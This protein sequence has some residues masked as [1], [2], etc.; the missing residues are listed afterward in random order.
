[1]CAKLIELFENPSSGEKEIITEKDIFTEQLACILIKTDPILFYKKTTEII[2][3]KINNNELIV[4]ILSENKKL[5]G[6]T[7]YPIKINSDRHSFQFP[8]IPKIFTTLILCLS[9]YKITCPKYLFF[10]IIQFLFCPSNIESL[11]IVFYFLSLIDFFF[12][13]IFM[14]YFLFI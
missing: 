9:R 6:E 2:E 8:S 11:K 7:F 10:E 5:E 4:N 1:V 12:Y 13:L 14:F 3:K